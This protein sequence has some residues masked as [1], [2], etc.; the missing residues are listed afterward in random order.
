MDYL[1]LLNHSFEMEMVCENPCLTKLAFLS[2]NIF[3]FTTYDRQKDELFGR[4]AIEVCHAISTRTTF[5]YIRDSDAYT[6]Y[7]VMCNMPFF[8]HKITW[9]TSIR[10]AS[11]GTNDA[12]P[13]S[14]DV[15]GLWDG[16][17]AIIKPIDFSNAE[18]AKFINALLEFVDD[19]I[20]VQ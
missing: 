5:E 6:W 2:Q 12:R 15:L 8:A 10:G 3:E 20:K 19:E 9:G 14:L 1:Q 17:T 4:K 7:L 16:D 13:I 11:W 18:W